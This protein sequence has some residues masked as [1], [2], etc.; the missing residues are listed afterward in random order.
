MF[1][2]LKRYKARFISKLR[3]CYQIKNFRQQKS[4]MN[5]K[6]ILYILHVSNLYL[7]RFKARRF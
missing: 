2:C 5:T 3:K 6:H 4:Y 1:F 7:K